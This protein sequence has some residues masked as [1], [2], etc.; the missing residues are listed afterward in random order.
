M[1]CGKRMHTGKGSIDA[2]CRDVNTGGRVWTWECK[3]VRLKTLTY[4]RCS[5][6][7]LGTMTRQRRGCRGFGRGPVVG[8]NAGGVRLFDC[9]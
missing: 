9:G 4:G 5:L 8:V 3:E 7:A 1:G 6:A 2:F